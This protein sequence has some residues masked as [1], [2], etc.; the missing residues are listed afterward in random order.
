MKQQHVPGPAAASGRGAA[1]TSLQAAALL[2]RCLLAAGLLAAGGPLSGLDLTVEEALR[3][4]EGRAEA[5]AMG[6]AD[7]RRAEQARMEAR[8]GTL[9][10]LSLEA[11]ASWMSNPPE[12]IAVEPGSLSAFPPIPAEELVFVEDSEP[13]Y[14]TLSLIL[15]QPLFTSLKLSS[16][17]RLAELGVEQAHWSLL[18]ARRRIGRDTASSYYAA[19]LARRS[20]EELRVS[21]S[22]LEEILRDVED[23]YAEGLVNF[24]SVL[25]V[26]KSLAEAERRLE[27]ARLNAAAGLQALQFY[28]EAPAEDLRLVSDFRKEPADID[29][30]PD[31]LKRA[32]LEYSGERRLLLLAVSQAE[33][34]AALRRGEMP[35]R[36]DLSLELRFDLEGGH[37]PWS[38]EDWDRSWRG[39]LLVS[40]GGRLPLFD[41]FESRA[42]VRQAE[43]R[44]EGARL[45][46]RRLEKSLALE[47][48]RIRREV[49]SAC[50]AVS[51]K[52]A[53]LE[54]AE[55][56]YKNAQ[57]S[58]EAEM[59]TRREERE[60]RLLLAAARLESMAASRDL[61]LALVR[62]EYLTGRAP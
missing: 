36:P 26:K 17:V 4:S 15:S 57:A 31:R 24:Q 53:A 27:E 48:V 60:A 30:D 43:E 5:I 59:L 21:R 41:S 40:L 54:L 55:E 42:G 29:L 35:L 37:V 61:S 2:A 23:A 16:A 10:S 7:L 3:L 46:L 50:C 49:V 25:E 62:L 47:S 33:R 20:L 1:R 38:E 28:T 6:R 32:A 39:N 51:E 44:I 56:V 9:P 52:E 45:A 58:L 22:L 12:G 18:A 13:T 19:L 34:G 14:F 8:A 11:S